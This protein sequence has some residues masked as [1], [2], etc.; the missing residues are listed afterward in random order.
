MRRNEKLVTIGEFKSCFD[1]DLAKLALDNADIE[2]IVMGAGACV[3]IFH[4]FFEQYVKL[5]VFESDVEWAKEVL[6]QGK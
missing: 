2:S 5:A 6:A 4:V 3:T 1:A